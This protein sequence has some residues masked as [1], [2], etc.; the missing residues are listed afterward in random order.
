MR[1]ALVTITLFLENTNVMQTNEFKKT[2]GDNGNLLRS[3]TRVPD[4]SFSYGA[5][6]QIRRDTN[7][8]PTSLGGLSL[9]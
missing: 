2:K 1:F 9:T 5:W 8:I 6:G 3:M 7:V 4:S